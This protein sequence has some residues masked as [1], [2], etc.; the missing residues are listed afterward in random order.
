MGKKFNTNYPDNWKEIANSTKE[1]NNWKCERCGHP[2]DHKSGH[3]LTIH[4]LDGNG[5]NNAAWNLACLCQRCHLHIQGIV[6]M[7]QSYMFP[8][9]EW[10][11]PHVEGYLKS[12]ESVK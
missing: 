10:M 6:E 4:H 12:L 1:K 3:T 2:H 5:E 9:S 7:S 11:R 8:H